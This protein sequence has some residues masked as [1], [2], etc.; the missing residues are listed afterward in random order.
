MAGVLGRRGA[1]EEDSRGVAVGWAGGGRGPVL[2]RVPWPSPRGTG[3]ERAGASSRPS[4][5][6]Q[7]E[8]RAPSQ[9]LLLIRFS[10]TG[11]SFWPAPLGCG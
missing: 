11:S 10:K 1:G 7:E 2:S 3:P 4:A 6:I 9:G 5:P 8:A